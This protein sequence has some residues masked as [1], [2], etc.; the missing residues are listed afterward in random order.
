M[1]KTQSAFYHGWHKRFSCIGGD[2]PLTCCCANGWNIS[3]SDKEMDMYKNLDSPLRDEILSAI[4]MDKKRFKSRGALYGPDDI[5]AGDCGLMTDDG[6]CKIVLNCGEDALTVVCHT[7][8]RSM[9]LKNDWFFFHVDLTCPVVS[10]YLF[11]EVPIKNEE[12]PEIPFVN[13]TIK[14]EEELFPFVID[15]RRFLEGLF[16]DIDGFMPGKLFVLF[17]Y[18]NTV[19]NIL[20]NDS[21]DIDKLYQAVGKYSDTNILGDILEECERIN[22]SDVRKAMLAK[23]ALSMLKGLICD[24]GSFGIKDAHIKDNLEYWIRGGLLE[25][26]APFYKYRDE[27]FPGFLD[28]YMAFKISFGL[29][30]WNLKPALKMIKNSYMTLFYIEMVGMSAWKN[31]GGHLS[32]EEYSVIISRI[33]R[34]ICH[35]TNANNVLEESIRNIE[36][37]TGYS[38][39][40]MPVY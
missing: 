33:E 11:D 38:L 16:I 28:K 23:V 13:E 25:D 18:V 10:K 37:G 26:L 40:M 6:L 35:S 1:K 24:V 31:N 17:D 3:I 39:Y 29:T 27:N 4:D 30:S 14:D 5:R 20:E 7:Y 36:D 8:P 32:A 9:M 19:I 2:C 22:T 34:R 15:S 12:Y 21:P